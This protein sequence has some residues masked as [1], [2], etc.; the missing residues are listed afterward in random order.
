MLIMVF[1]FCTFWGPIGCSSGSGDYSREP[2]ELGGT[3]G[4]TSQFGT[5]SGTCYSL[6]GRSARNRADKTPPGYEPVSGVTVTASSSP[7]P[8]TTDAKG[9]FIF[10]GLPAGPCT[11]IFTKSGLKTVTLNVTIKGGESL[12]VTSSGYSGVIL[13][14][15]PTNPAALKTWSYICYIAADNNLADLS[16]YVIDLMET[17]DF[18]A[19]M[20]VLV[21]QDKAGSHSKMYYVT[22]DSA[23]GI[24]SPSMDY[25]SN[26]DSGIPKTLEDFMETAITLYP[27]EHHIVD[28]WN[29]GSGP[30]YRSKDGAIRSVAPLTR[31]VCFDDTSGHSLTMPQY[32]DALAFIRG[33]LGHNIEVHVMSFCLMGGYET[34]YQ[35]R[36]SVDYALCS[37]PSLWGSIRCPFQPYNTFMNTIT[38]NPAYTAKQMCQALAQDTYNQH[39]ALLGNH[40]CAFAAADLSKI[41]TVQTPFADFADECSTATADPAMLLRLRNDLLSTNVKQWDQNNSWT[42]YLVDLWTVANEYANDAAL[43]AALRTAATNTANAL[44]T[45]ANN[46][47]YWSAYHNTG[48]IPEGG[49]FAYDWSNCRMMSILTRWSSAYDVPESYNT[50]LDL[51]ADTCW[52]EFNANLQP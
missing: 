30:A 17:V 26:L 25:G 4:G 20:H 27:S 16:D 5:I 51:S 46:F 12:T 23:A 52:N 36:N 44:N 29:H 14:P 33:I 3:G 11:L 31:N 42:C 50:G 45:G 8:T 43:P 19:N 48:R 9:S 28:M 18:S 6:D 10:H 49:T 2:L 7:N 24:S 32:K 1:L 34:M 41:S 35:I 39:V 21:F 37:P 22:P 40:D 15:T 13:P 47:I 38:S